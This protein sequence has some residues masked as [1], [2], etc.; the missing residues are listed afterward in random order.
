MFPGS[1]S[2]SVEF[3]RMS[4]ENKRKDLP[5]PAFPR[6]VREHVRY[7]TQF[8][9]DLSGWCVSNITSA[10]IAFDTSTTSRVLPRPV[11]GTCPS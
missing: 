5:P 3:V 8:N 4:E 1:P 2:F 10:P 7:A 9:Q 6:V 11:W